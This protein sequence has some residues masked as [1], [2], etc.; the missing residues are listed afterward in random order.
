MD[1]TSLASDSKGKRDFDPTRN[2]KSRKIE[3]F[4]RKILK[5]PIPPITSLLPPSARSPL[6]HGYPVG[7]QEARDALVTALGLRVL[8]GGGN[9]L[10]SDGSNARLPTKML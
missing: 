1:C 9:Y 10:H 4:S 8:M 6:H 2:S 7:T 5:G 3:N